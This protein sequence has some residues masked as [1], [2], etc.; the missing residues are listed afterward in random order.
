LD[1]PA[2]INVPGNVGE[3]QS[4]FALTLFGAAFLAVI[5][6]PFDERPI[7]ALAIAA[8]L[9]LLAVLSQRPILEWRW[10]LTALVLVILLIPIRRYVLPP[11]L[12]F[13]PEPYRLLIVFLLFGWILSALADPRVRL[14]R[15][16]LEIPIGLIVFTTM[17][18]EMANLH[19]VT[20]VQD[21]VAKSLTFFA[22]FFVVFYLMISVVRMVDIRFIVKTLV[23]GG[24]GVALFAIVE[25]R[26]GFNVF[27]RLGEAL[28]FLEPTSETEELRSGRVRAFGSAQHPIAL[29]AA[30]TMILPLA[31]YL[32]RVAG[33]RWLLAALLLFFGSLATLSRTSVVMLI[34]VGVV[35][36]ILRSREVLRLWPLVI[37]FAVATHFVLPGALGTI[38]QSFF[39]AQGLEGF[40]QEHETPLAAPREFSF[41]WCQSAARLS[42]IGPALEEAKQ[43]PLLGSGF[44]TRITGDREISNACILDNQWLGTLLET[45]ALGV[46]GW[47]LLFVMFAY[48]A[49]RAAKRDLS[50]RGWLL[51]AST[52]SVV[53][54]AM[55]MLFFDAL[56]FIQVTFILFFILALG[57]IALREGK[58][59]DGSD[60]PEGAAWAR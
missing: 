26:T 27:D 59:Q 28:P 37:V 30:L 4:A 13:Q 25:F 2:G 19:R 51:T 36:L 10:A 47:L 31:V 56:S 40:I 55:G 16:G 42:D 58:A 57:A 6:A 17:A 44:A 43:K 50:E 1:T 20:S 18:S 35:F 8:L 15:S 14:R 52:A 24:A 11:V 34:A 33:R 38:K 3:R 39:P 53:S 46:L 54:F 60:P 48:T 5:V 41:A 12:P 21:E 9:G 49:G 45:G 22:T 7:A 32:V 29:G 23:A